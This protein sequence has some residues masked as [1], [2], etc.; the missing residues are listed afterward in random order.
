LGQET[1]P[2]CLIRGL[3]EGGW[4][5]NY[6]KIVEAH[7]CVTCTSFYCFDMQR[8]IGIRNVTYT[9]GKETG[10][11]VRSNKKDDFQTGQVVRGIYYEYIGLT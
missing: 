11:Y 10:K 8:M 7:R 9:K 5:N 4:F 2:C 6:C 1:I 3:P